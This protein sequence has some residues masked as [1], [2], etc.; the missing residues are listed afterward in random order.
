MSLLSKIHLPRDFLIE[1]C[2][3]MSLFLTEN[4]IFF[5]FVQF[6][7]SFNLLDLD[8]H[9]SF[10]S[11]CFSL[12]SENLPSFMEDSGHSLLTLC[13]VQLN[14]IK[15]LATPEF[16][17][18]LH[19]FLQTSYESMP[20]SAAIYTVFLY[21]SLSSTVDLQFIQQQDS[22]FL[23]KIFTTDSV[24]G[25]NLVCILLNLFPKSEGRLFLEKCTTFTTFVGDNSLLEY[26]K[27]LSL[28]TSEE[29][30]ADDHV[31]KPIISI[32]FERFVNAPSYHKSVFEFLKSISMSCPSILS[33]TQ[34][35]SIIESDFDLD[36]VSHMIGYRRDEIVS[37]SSFWTIIT[38]NI[39]VNYSDSTI[40]SLFN[41]SDT[42]IEKLSIETLH[43]FITCILALI[44]FD[45]STVTHLLSI[46]E[47][48]LQLEICQEH[49]ISNTLLSSSVCQTLFSS[50]MSSDFLLL[51]SSLN[52]VFELLNQVQ[53]VYSFSE[54]LTYFTKSGDST[55]FNLSKFLKL[56]F[57][58]GSR[59]RCSVNSLVNITQIL[60][61]RLES[62]LPN[63]F[64]ESLHFELSKSLLEVIPQIVFCFGISFSLSEGVKTNIVH[65]IQK[66]HDSEDFH[67]LLPYLVSFS[68]INSEFSN[69][70]ADHLLLLM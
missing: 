6:L 28:F 66:Q 64:S 10:Y 62:C 47:N 44:S 21:V 4:S 18:T 63:A 31:F 56:T 55:L 51:L 35:L 5:N 15:H 48:C 70:L 67:V 26:F 25:V 24:I 59:E 14:R 40:S 23:E 29:I 11:T 17:S 53:I 58:C 42:F 54:L 43:S 1:F 61:S 8:L 20:F 3:K 13:C 41:N 50:C 12:L 27:F 30:S 39:R 32:V 69:I 52:S 37:S 2:P 60:M 22:L 49:D 46:L 57:K 36:Y 33:S 16:D 68:K 65:L 7:N 9:P 19:H 34:L 38:Q 45:S